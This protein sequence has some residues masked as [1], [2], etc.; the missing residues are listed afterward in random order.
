MA[1]AP[2][3]PPAMMQQATDPLAELRDIHVPGMIET[4][5]PAP[6][7]W[8]LAIIGLFMVIALLFWLVQRWQRSR[9]RREAINELKSLSDAWASHQDDA[10]YLNSLQHLLKR[11][12]LTNFPREDVASLTGEAWVQFLDQSTGS[13][14]FS[15]AE[16]DALIDGNYRP[17]LNI[18]VATLES[19]AKQ[20]INKHNIRHLAAAQARQVT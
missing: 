15:M 19:V 11:V 2:T 20:W 3:L 9:Y 7:W 6:G 1:A 18:D 8:I 14:D 13:H 5:P 17:D 12:A 16:T 4:W 10:Q